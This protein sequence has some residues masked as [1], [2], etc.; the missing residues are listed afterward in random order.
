MLLTASGAVECPLSEDMILDEVLDQIHIM[1]A[2]F[3]DELTGVAPKH[4]VLALR[5]G[6]E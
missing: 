5:G 4:A 1:E 3:N 6:E 2:A